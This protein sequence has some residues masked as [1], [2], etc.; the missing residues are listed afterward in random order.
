LCF[1]ASNCQHKVL[2][3][4]FKQLPGINLDQVNLGTILVIYLYTFP[5]LNPF[6]LGVI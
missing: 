6:S 1:D 5:S 4:R 2:H 3:S